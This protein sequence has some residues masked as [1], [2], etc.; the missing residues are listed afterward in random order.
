MFILGCLDLENLIFF[1]NLISNKK[2]SAHAHA[3]CTLH[4]G[5]FRAARNP[6]FNPLPWNTEVQFTA[7]LRRENP[8]FSTSSQRGRPETTHLSQCFWAKR[9]LA[10]ISSSTR[11][12]WCGLLPCT[13]ELGIAPSQYVLP[14][15]QTQS[16]WAVIGHAGSQ[17]VI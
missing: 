12:P 15:K 3:C 10:V 2:A 5:T 1:L 17:T 9:D 13:L 14:R 16:C 11:P 7:V 4:K 6:C 8:R